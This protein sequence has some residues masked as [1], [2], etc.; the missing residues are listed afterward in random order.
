MAVACLLNLGLSPYCGPES[1]SLCSRW[2]N[3]IWVR[4]RN[5][6]FPIG[7]ING[8]RMDKVTPKVNG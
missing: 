4:V 2:A 6:G 7:L 5:R 8:Q 3:V 1:Q